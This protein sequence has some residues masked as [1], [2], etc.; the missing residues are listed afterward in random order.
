MARCE[1]TNRETVLAFINNH[2]ADAG[3]EARYQAALAA[4]EQLRDDAI[5]TETL[6][7]A[8]EAYEIVR[9][10]I[11]HPRPNDNQSCVNALEALEWMRADGERQ[12]KIEDAAR[13]LMG[14]TYSTA[15]DSLVNLQNKLWDTLKGGDAPRPQTIQSEGRSDAP[16]DIPCQSDRR[17][18][19]SLALDQQAIAGR[20]TPSPGLNQ[21]AQ[22]VHQTE[23]PYQKALIAQQC[24]CLVMQSL[25][26][27]ALK[28]PRCE[29]LQAIYALAI[30]Q[31]LTKAPKPSACR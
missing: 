1:V 10:I 20:P 5:P 26:G 18:N 6:M 24:Y 2:V 17:V 3:Y 19:P 31:P 13:E 12:Q 14:W 9:E 8:S 16:A 27:E 7:T 4:L 29:A 23:C 25:Y 30:T 21:A 28:C 22:L 15:T 11:I